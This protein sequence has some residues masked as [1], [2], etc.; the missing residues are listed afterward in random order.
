MELIGQE[1]IQEALE[2]RKEDT[3]SAMASR[4]ETK[5]IPVSR[6]RSS[7]SRKRWRR[8]QASHMGSL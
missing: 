6:G 3:F 1:E 8:G 5:S 4:L 7:S 2:V